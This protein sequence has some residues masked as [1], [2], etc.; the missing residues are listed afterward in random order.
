[1]GRC[2][3]KEL[4]LIENYVYTPINAIA[5]QTLLAT[6]STLQCQPL[7]P[8]PRPAYV[9]ANVSLHKDACPVCALSV[10]QGPR[11]RGH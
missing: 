8:V 1:M 10:R 4:V 7:G 2:S 9:K 6:Q 5:D 3:T 11:T